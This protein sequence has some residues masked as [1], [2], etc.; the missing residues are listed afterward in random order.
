MRPSRTDFERALT[1][2]LW[3]LAGLSGPLR[4]AV[5]TGTC[6]LGPLRG[7]DHQCMQVSIVDVER[8]CGGEGTEAECSGNWQR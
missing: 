3:L 1:R 7:L 5:G 8:Q 2:R 6:R 4:C